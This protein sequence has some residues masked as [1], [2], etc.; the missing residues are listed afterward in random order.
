MVPRSPRSR[1]ATRRCARV[2]CDVA[3]ITAVDRLFAA[4]S[5]AFGGL[6]AL[7]NNAGIAGPTA[8]CEDVT[9]P[10]W[11]RTLAVNLTSQFLCA[12]RAIP[13]LKASRNASIAN[14]SSAAGRF[15]FPLRTPYSASKWGVIGLTKSLAIELGA[16]GVRVNA[17]CPGSVA[18]PRIDRVFAH[19]AA[20]RGVAPEIVRD[21]ALVRTSLRRLVTADDIAHAIVFLASPLGSNVSGQRCRSTPIRTRSFEERSMA[22]HP[23]DL[24]G[25]IALITGAYRGLGYAIARGLGE[26]GATV[27]LNGR[28]PEA[29]AEA[30]KALTEGGLR[31]STSVFDVVQGDAVR[32]AVGAIEREHGR[33]DILVNNAGIQR[34]GPLVDFKQQDWD[35]IIATN[36]T[37]PFLV[38][39]AVLP[40]MIARKHGKIINIASLMSELA[41]PTVVPYTA[42]KGG[43]RQLTRGMAI[44]L[45]PHNIQVNAIS[46]GYFATEMNRALI[47]NAEFNAW[48]CKRT[49]AAAG[50][51][52][53]EI[54]GLAVFL[55]SSAANYITGQLITIDGGMS[56]AL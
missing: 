14:L 52:P 17:I 49:P 29:L 36:L 2:D 12:Q 40:G 3:D 53:A 30:A 26:A 13:L 7:V 1:P 50:A 6:D 31:A 21:E 10:D 54:A 28:R 32:A 47:D 16:F 41:R 4:V 15:G 5:A 25:Q 23:F 38:A 44:E 22:K 39:Q 35:D 42:A 11:E 43:V 27:V 34:R 20:A 51:S 19:K 56:V 8:A 9:L 55:A 18:G 37:A 24:T 45:A 46:P 33:V 48:V